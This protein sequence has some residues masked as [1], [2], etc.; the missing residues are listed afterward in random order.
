MNISYPWNSDLAKFFKGENGFIFNA[1]TDPK[2]LLWLASHTKVQEDI[3]DVL[4]KNILPCSNSLDFHLFLLALDKACLIPKDNMKYLI[5]I[6]PSLDNISLL[7][8]ST[9]F[10]LGKIFYRISELEHEDIISFAS[11]ITE[12]LD[13][14]HSQPLLQCLRGSLKDIVKSIPKESLQDLRSALSHGPVSGLLEFDTVLSS[15]FSDNNESFYA[16]FPS[17]ATIYYKC[18]PHKIKF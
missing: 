15:L 9:I 1:K 13:S 6:L 11:I 18:H 8:N 4:S 2:K 17:A 14:T 5:S 10:V 12:Y 3:I 16:L 7:H